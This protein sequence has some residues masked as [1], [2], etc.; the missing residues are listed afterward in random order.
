MPWHDLP[1]FYAGLPDT[2]PGLTLRLIILTG[3][4][5]G[6]ALNAT[7]EE[8]SDLDGTACMWTIQASRM[9]RGREHEIPLAGAAVALL[10]R[11]AEFRV[12]EFVFPGRIGANKPISDFAVRQ[13]LAGTEATLHGFRA[14]F[15]TW[16]AEA[17]VRR[18][19]AEVALA[20]SFGDRTEQAYQRSNFIEERRAVMEAWAAV[21]TGSRRRCFNLDAE[22][23]HIDVGG[24]D[25]GF[26]S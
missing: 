25:A 12:G 20:H 18:E 3:T 6:E 1:A 13:L 7:W 23:G 26:S 16:A 4:R 24:S 19:I 9:K 8:I 2:V 10:R 11:A 15:R 5:L 17:G 22:P 21:V 14:S